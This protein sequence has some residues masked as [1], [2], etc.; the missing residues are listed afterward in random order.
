[1]KYPF[2]N[3]VAHWSWYVYILSSGFR[4]VKRM[5]V[6]DSTPPGRDTN[7]S[8][9]RFQQMLVLITD[10]GRMKSCVLKMNF[11]S[12]NAAN[13]NYTAI[14]PEE[15]LCIKCRHQKLNR[16]QISMSFFPG[17]KRYKAQTSRTQLHC[18]A[19]TY[20]HAHN[21]LHPSNYNVSNRSNRGQLFHPC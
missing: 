2:S 6:F 18:F 12:C 10:F 13:R 5:R 15:I 19:R 14:L 16:Y 11:K 1:M 4:S 17:V 7:Q 20:T 21:R 3:L 8:Q 9:V